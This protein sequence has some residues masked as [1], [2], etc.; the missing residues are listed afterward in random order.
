MK[1]S[2]RHAIC[3]GALGQGGHVVTRSGSIWLGRVALAGA[4]AAAF[5][6]AGCGKKGPLDAPPL[7]ASEPVPPGQPPAATYSPNG[8]PNAPA[9]EKRRTILDWLID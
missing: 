8:K 6:V 1:V 3:Y 7:A 2:E 4:L 5:A 9:E